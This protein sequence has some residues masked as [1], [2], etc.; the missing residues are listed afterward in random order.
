MA[1]EMLFSAYTRPLADRYGI[2]VF[3]QGTDEKNLSWFEDFVQMNLDQERPFGLHADNVKA[4]T[5]H[6]ADLSDSGWQLLLEQIKRAQLYALGEK[7][8]KKAAGRYKGENMDRAGE[9][10]EEIAGQITDRGA[11]AA[12]EAKAQ[13]SGAL[14]AEQG[15]GVRKK[16]ESGKT[17]ADQAP[18]NQGKED[19]RPGIGR[20]VRSGLLNI[21]MGDKS[22]S[23]RRAD[24]SDCTYQAAEGGDF[25]ISDNFENYKDVADSLK[26]K[27]LSEVFGQDVSANSKNMLLNIYVLDRFGSLRKNASPKSALSYEAEYILFGHPSDRENLEST[28]TS[29]YALRTALNLAYLYQ[30]KGMASEAVKA[31]SSVISGVLPAAASLVR[32]LILACWAGAE[33]A[34]DCAALAEGKKVPLMK[35]ADSW[36]L[37]L[38]QLSRIASKGGRAASYVKSG[39]K[40]L[41]YSQY[42]S[43]LL[44]PLPRKKKIK[45]MLQLMEKNIRLEPDMADFR[46]SR[47]I[48]GAK[49]EVSARI[50]PQF[51]RWKGS[52]DCSCRAAYI[53]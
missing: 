44:M 18:V 19:P 6:K 17:P 47:C 24:M 14:P 32:I 28:M 7:G 8:L 45:R 11:L 22:I 2:F 42:L 30:N 49:F 10:S 9:L 34:V 46:F 5:L 52:I 48:A 38:D 43:L 23:S 20:W 36:N 3:D 26:G 25:N 4:Q 41:D 50:R 40:G 37:S 12:D 13:E 53:Y 39:D 33:A 29:L 15:E 51:W 27:G 16:D 31:F 1:A 35:S 21:V